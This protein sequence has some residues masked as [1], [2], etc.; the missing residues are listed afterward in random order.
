MCVWCSATIRS[1]YKPNGQLRKLS[2]TLKKHAQVLEFQKPSER[3]L[4]TWI[5]RH[6]RA[7]GKLIS[8]KLASY[9][10]F[11][12]GG[13]MTQLEGEIK[14]FRPTRPARKSSAQILTRWSRPF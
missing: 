6:F 13:G 11:L 14:K 9:L 2:E 7:E 1:E 8:D 3:E 10:I 4:C 12:T 5:A